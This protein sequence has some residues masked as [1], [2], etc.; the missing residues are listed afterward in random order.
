MRLTNLF[1]RSALFI[2][3]A[4]TACAVG[5]TVRDGGGSGDVR[6][7]DTVMSADAD[8]T[9]VS[10]DVPMGTDV[11]GTDTVV[12]PD[13]GPV[14]PMGQTMCGTSCTNTTS[15]PANCG[16]CGTACATG[17]L[18]N[19]GTC[20]ARCDPPRMVCMGMGGAMSCVDVQTDTANCGRCGMACAMGQSCTAGT[21]ACPAGRMLCGTACADTMSDPSNCGRCGGACM[22][23]NGTP[24]CV[25]GACSV[26]SCSMGFDDCN[27]MPADGCETNLA[28]SAA[29]CGACFMPCMLPNAMATCAGGMC[30]LG[31]CNAGFANCDGTAA[32]GCEANTSSSTTNCGTCGRAC[33][34][35]QSCAAGVCGCPAGQTVC[36]AACV[37]T[38]TD[39]NNCGLCGTVCPAGRSCV[40][41]TCACPAGQTLCGGVCVNL[42]TDTANC[43]AC[44]RACTAGMSCTAGACTGG[45]PVN[46]A[47]ASATPLSL[48]AGT[49]TVSGTTVGATVD[50]SC[51]GGP[52]VWYSVTLAS[53]EALYANTFGSGYDTEIG[54]YSACGALVAG[55]C[56]DDACGTLQS[57][58]MVV[59]N[60]GTY[61]I[62]VGGFGG[63]SGAFTLRVQHVPVP[64]A[65]VSTG[66]LAAGTTTSSG[67]T[68]GA[69]TFAV[70][71]GFMGA[72]RWYHWLSCPTAV[73]GAVTGTTC[74]PLAAFDTVLSLRNGDGIGNACNDDSCG[75]Q[76]NLSGS[77]S[78]GAGLHVFFMSS[79]STAA[80]AYQVRVVH[81]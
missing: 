52:D 59:L 16:S 39:P 61:R 4:S 14:C 49:T 67:T 12:P 80:G 46:N 34:A 20:S 26:L 2:A 41:G 33:A 66:V 13:T 45:G 37:N 11:V 32:N 18:C 7:V 63:G 72:T 76:S 44:G 56:I 19:A 23:A 74:S 15:D 10:P 78:A 9:A 24:S 81:P 77:A 43:G 3:F 35:G 51:G 60:A 29:N 57:Q 21:C 62:S 69:P 79:Y 47:C 27:R 64:A 73:A 31:A 71:C 42:S 65:S 50:G 36:G 68:V 28:T 30:A 48:L 5:Q 22:V 25:A 17:Q 40:G 1:A 38:S 8:D 70:G 54:V 75:L 53:R 6:G 55:G 58:V